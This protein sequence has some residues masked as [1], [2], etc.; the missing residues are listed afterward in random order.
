MYVTR[1][2]ADDWTANSQQDVVTERPELAQIEQALRGLD[3][4]R[5]T[6]VVLGANET[7]Y[8]GIGGGTEGHF[9]VFINYNDEEF[10]SLKNSD[11]TISEEESFTL[12][13]GGRRDEYLARQCIGREEML[14]A[15]LCFATDGSREPS[16]SWERQEEDEDEEN[17]VLHERAVP[18]SEDEE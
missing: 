6:L 16:L 14:R 10:Y 8:M 17:W 11:P 18:D 1:L 5:H 13:I 3:G 9:V 7:T 4:E 12:T 15:A 2:D